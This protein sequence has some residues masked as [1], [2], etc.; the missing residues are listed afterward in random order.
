MGILASWSDL[1]RLEDVVGRIKFGKNNLQQ[2]LS[3]HGNLQKSVTKIL[4]LYFT[5]VD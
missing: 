1:E 3:V 2:D 4:A 5:I